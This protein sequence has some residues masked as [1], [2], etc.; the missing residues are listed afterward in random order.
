MLTCD[1]NAQIYNLSDWNRRQL[2]K[3]LV[4]EYPFL[5]PRMLSTDTIS[6]DYDYQYTLLDDIPS[7]WR[8]E[9]GIEMCEEMKK[10]LEKYNMLKDYRIFQLKEKFGELRIYGNW[11]NEEFDAVIKKYTDYSKTVC[12]RC[13]NRAV[14]Y[15]MYKT[16]CPIC[17]HCAEK[18][19]KQNHLCLDLLIPIDFYLEELKQNKNLKQICKEHK[20]RRKD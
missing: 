5:L 17:H 9:F 18:L 19:D 7:G 4:E 3:K 12:Y 11:G 14:F 10:V 8:E 13:G 15:D 20:E 1:N 6:D 16:G 2:N